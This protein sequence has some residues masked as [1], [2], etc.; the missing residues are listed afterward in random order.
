MLQAQESIRFLN[1]MALA[2]GGMPQHKADE[3]IYR[4][5]A[6][7]AGRSGEEFESVRV[8]RPRSPEELAMLAGAGTKVFVSG[9]SS[10]STGK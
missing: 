6:A 3:H 5:Q 1:D 9:S 4:L 2:Q 7:A 10:S 8:A